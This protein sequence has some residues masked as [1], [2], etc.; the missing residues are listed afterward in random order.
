[1]PLCIDSL[2]YFGQ[3][4]HGP[5]LDSFFLELIDRPAAYTR[6]ARDFLKK[7]IVLSGSPRHQTGVIVVP[8]MTEK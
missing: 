7:T 6:I 3:P 2:I 1:M 8:V 4:F 5:L